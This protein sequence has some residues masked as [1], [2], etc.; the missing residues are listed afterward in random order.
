MNGDFPDNTDLSNSNKFDFDVKYHLSD[1]PSS[2][3]S[4]LNIGTPP[5]SPPPSS[6]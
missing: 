1:A 6:S 3:H 5:P 4:W 2:P